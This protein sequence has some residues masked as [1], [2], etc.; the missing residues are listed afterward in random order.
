MPNNY[1]ILIIDDDDAVR[2]SIAVY[3][4]EVGY[5]VYQASDGEQ[6]VAL[7]QELLPDVV[8]C[9]LRMPKKDG[10]SVL[11]EI[12]AAS[13]DTPIIVISGAGEITEVV[14]ALRFGAN[15]YF[16][17]P[18]KDIDALEKSISRCLEQVKLRKQNSAYREKLEQTNRQLENHLRI[19][20]QDQQAGRHVQMRLLPPSP[21]T[22]GPYTFT[23]RVIPSLYLSGDFVEYILVGDNYIN[24]YIADISG[25]GAS[26]AFVTAILKDY[27]AHQ[28]SDY[29]RHGVHTVIEP[30]AF[31]QRA[32]NALLDSGIGKHMT[33]CVGVLD[34]KANTLRYS[35]AGHLPEPILVTA[36][37]AKYLPGSGM[38]VGLFKE[39]EFN[40]Q[41]IDLPEKFTLYMFSDGV[42]EILPAKQLV[43]KETA[44]LESMQNAPQDLD[45]LIDSFGVDTMDEIPD[46]IA[47]LM[48][49]RG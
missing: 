10:I 1:S 42:L 38:P 27:T 26:S 14:D 46:D 35:T 9:D 15:D 11:R 23:H 43:D 47:V 31:L 36:Q 17:K 3:L 24:F 19:L 28:R 20:E 29:N 25:H 49:K 12:N 33:M 32:N 44:L 41:T 16:I 18:I 2:D 6:G 4:D 22:L 48:V 21:H 30:I 39:A 40:E 45:S 5:N 37:G 13:P 7:Q 34:I 8:L